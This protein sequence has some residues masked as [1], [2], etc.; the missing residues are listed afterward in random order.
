MVSAFLL[1]FW[2]S[3]GYSGWYIQIKRMGMPDRYD[4]FM[5][6]PMML[7]GPIGLW[8]SLRRS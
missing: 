5:I 1:L 6:G 8:L 4:A 3:L 2:C 7:I